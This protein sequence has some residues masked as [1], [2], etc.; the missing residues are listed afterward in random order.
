MISSGLDLQRQRAARNQAVCRDVNDRIDELNE[1][2]GSDD[3]LP[4]YICE[5]LDVSC[6]ERIAIPHHDYLRIR[7]NPVEFVVVPG[8]EDLQVEQVID[9]ETSWLIVR[10]LGVGAKVAAELAQPPAK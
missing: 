5:C 3:A 6:G 8:H 2:L 4:Q 7:R 1:Q 10:K 9:R